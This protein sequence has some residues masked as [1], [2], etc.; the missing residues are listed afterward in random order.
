MRILYHHRTLGDGAEGVHI[1]E[2]VEAF[3]ALGHE[4]VVHAVVTPHVQSQRS[5]SIAHLKALLPQSLFELGALAYNG[6]ELV[7]IRRA[8]RRY[9]PDLVYKRHALFDLGAILAARSLRIPIVLEVNAAYS[10]PVYQ[11]LERFHFIRLA[12]L[13][14]R[15][16]IESATLVAAVSTP[17]RELLVA[18]APRSSHIIVVPNAANPLRFSPT[19]EGVAEVRRMLGTDAGLLVGWCGI[20]RDWHGLELLLGAVQKTAGLRLVIIGDGPDAPRL[21]RIA[22]ERGLAD[23]TVFTGRVPHDRIPAYIAALDIAVAADDRTGYA[24]PMKVLEYM[25]AGRAVVAPRLPGVEDLIEDQIDGVLFTPRDEDA[26]A[27]ALARLADDTQLRHEL[28][29][30]ARRKIE[31]E[32]NW[33]RNAETVLA[34]L[35]TPR[36][37]EFSEEVGGLSALG[38]A[39]RSLISLHRAP[40][41][42]QSPRRSTNGSRTDE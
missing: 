35:E 29:R 30:R 25:A 24:S 18:V 21:Q 14:E 36:G 1:Q 10:S 5:S 26:L 2:M 42:A 3:E 34:A 13:C 41:T 11:A 32:R 33:Q 38:C 22:R 7:M 6:V 40:A 20:L 31:S 17:L 4:V 15:L 16:S 27:A 19:V 8:I 9:R 12:H 23:R 28:G 39:V 37:R